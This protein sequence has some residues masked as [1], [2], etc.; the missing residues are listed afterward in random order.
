MAY[1]N[2]HFVFAIPEGRTPGAIWESGS[3][4]TL[5]LTP[6]VGT[7]L[8]SL[9]VQGPTELGYTIQ[10]STDLISWRDLS[11]IVDNQPTNLILDALPAPSD[12][13]FYRAYS[14]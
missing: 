5:A 1:G 9:S 13:V 10:T 4:I 2:G 14:Q 11:N 7:R 12:R 6:I 8:L 3:I